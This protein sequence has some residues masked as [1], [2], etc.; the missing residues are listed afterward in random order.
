[1]NRA[2]AFRCAVHAELWPLPLRPCHTQEPDLHLAFYRACRRSWPGV[3]VRLCAGELPSLRPTPASQA[4]SKTVS[5]LFL[6]GLRYG[7]LGQMYHGRSSR[8]GS[9]AR[10]E[11]WMMFQ[12]SPRQD[13]SL[14]F[15]AQSRHAMHPCLLRNAPGGAGKSLKVDLEKRRASHEPP[16]HI[17]RSLN[18]PSSRRAGRCGDSLGLTDYIRRTTSRVSEC[19]G[20]AE[21]LGN[22]ETVHVRASSCEQMLLNGYWLCHTWCGSGAWLQPN[23]LRASKGAAQWTKLARQALKT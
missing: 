4:A 1:M 19:V 7:Q 23:C 20:G 11:G 22:G 6:A 13:T 9:P 3:P 14:P 17:S 2:A 18:H 10:M 16:R 21:A 8:T 5:A 12:K 15:S